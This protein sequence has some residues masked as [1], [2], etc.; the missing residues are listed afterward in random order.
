[1]KPMVLKEPTTCCGSP[2]LVRVVG[3]ER[4]MCPCGKTLVNHLGRSVAVK[5][6]INVKKR[7]RL[8]N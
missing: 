4:Y 1:M 2:T 8:R 3:K 7:P 5:T 6:Y